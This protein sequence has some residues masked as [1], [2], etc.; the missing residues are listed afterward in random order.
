MLIAEQMFQ[1]DQ[2][3]EIRW[4]HQRQILQD[5]ERIAT[6]QNFQEEAG[7]AALQ[8][9]I[10]Y[11]VGFG[12][13]PNN[14][15]ATRFLRRAEELGHPMVVLFGRVLQSVTSSISADPCVQYDSLVVKGFKEQRMLKATIFELHIK[16]VS[17]P[18]TAQRFNTYNDFLVW[19]DGIRS[20]DLSQLSTSYLTT[21][22][23][24]SKMNIFECFIA[25]EDVESIIKWTDVVTQFET[26]VFGEPLLIQ[27][28]RK[29]NVAMVQALLEAGVDPERCTEEG[30]T[31]YHLLFMLGEGART[32]GRLLSKSPMTL[33]KKLYDQ[34]G[35]KQ[36]ILHIQWPLELLGSPLAFAITSASM[37]GVAAL[38]DIGADPTAPIHMQSG[39]DDSKF[40]WT[41]IHLAMKFHLSD[42]LQLLLTEAR[43]RSLDLNCSPPSNQAI[44][45]VMLDQA[46]KDSSKSEIELPFSQN[47]QAELGCG[48]VYS[49]PLERY[50]MH[51]LN[52][53]QKLLDT[54][55]SVPLAAFGLSRKDGRTAII[56]AIDFSDLA[57]VDAL[58]QLNPA[59]AKERVHDPKNRS[60]YDTP[61]AFACQIAALRDSTAALDIVKT[62]IQTNAGNLR[63]QDSQGRTA[64]HLAVTGSSSAVAEWLL[65]H[66]ASVHDL[67]GDG[68][69]PLHYAGSAANIRILLDA[70]AQIDRTDKKGFA[71]IHLAALAG[72][73][74]NVKALIERG[75]NLKIAN[76]E[77]GTPLHCA[78][79]KRSRSIISALLKHTIST[80]GGPTI[81]VNSQDSGTRNTPLHL[82]AQTCRADIVR[83]LFEYGANAQLKN[84]NKL[85][86]LHQ[87]VLSG[88]AVFVRSFLAAAG[89]LSPLI[90]ATDSNG[91]TPLHLAATFASWET[92]IL[93]LEHG[94]EVDR[95]SNDGF[96][97]LHLAMDASDADV[98]RKEGDRLQTCKALYSHGADLLAANNLG[99]C[100]WDLALQRLDFALMGLLLEN[101]GPKACRYSTMPRNAHGQDLLNIAIDREEW[102][103]VTL[104][105]SQSGR[106]HPYEELS[107][108]EHFPPRLIEFRRLPEFLQGFEYS[109]AI[110]LDE[111]IRAKDK[112]ALRS[113]F[114]SSSVTVQSVEQDFPA[115]S[116]GQSR[117][118]WICQMISGKPP[119]K[120]LPTGEL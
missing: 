52:H 95:R 109:Y 14:D 112:S 43:R 72:L 55:K 63:V 53:R 94:A 113:M 98:N 41:P 79:F 49:T 64:L 48:V 78:V 104:L 100:A 75:A 61:V 10:C 110:K 111:A 46:N 12:T 92:V 16:D 58:L 54:M 115:G 42:I 101:G 97:A 59:L 73:E 50:A 18:I 69:T 65:D 21:V 22:P 1:E 76:Y 103:F 89:P 93:L 96:T 80:N 83:L 17:S 26:T 33:N 36:Y 57:V 105:L 30:L 66:G 85:T 116:A 44:A 9:A 19:L 67:D 24:T 71:A 81:D 82:A 39:T 91:R 56:Q 74:E 88:S 29:A 6:H 106:A 45:S 13:S 5:F 120:R 32:I 40:S 117:N 11:I 47:F 15:N 23:P 119:G 2:E 7:A 31:I 51:G 34:P 86:P 28:C 60:S 102:A 118:S 62:L 37:A 4:E 114:A 77:F 108:E 68:R 70:K 84:K 87:C 3:R 38:L 27:A 25:M 107:E 8:V 90:D 35:S 20:S 99:I